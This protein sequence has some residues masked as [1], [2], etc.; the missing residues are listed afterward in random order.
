MQP[1]RRRRRSREPESGRARAAV[2]IDA[3]V[4][5]ADGPRVGL[6][7]AG[8]RPNAIVATWL[9]AARFG[10][11]DRCGPGGVYVSAS[12]K[13]EFGIAILEAMASGLVVVAPWEGGPATYVE[14]GVTGVLADTRSPA[15][16]AAA[17]AAAFDLAAA[18]GAK[19]RAAG[20]QRLVRERFSVH[21]MAAA[22]AAIYQDVAP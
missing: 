15:A 4:A 9:A 10:R 7:L 3:A 5:R 22:L 14:D 2:R 6:L 16:L 20:A 12:L 13:E 8:H 1:P 21:T 11:P 18:P 17:V 19:R